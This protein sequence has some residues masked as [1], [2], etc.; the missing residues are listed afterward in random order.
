MGAS[1][2]TELGQGHSLIRTDHRIRILLSVPLVNLD[3]KDRSWQTVTS[4]ASSQI[5]L[6]VGRK[7][8]RCGTNHV[9]LVVQEVDHTC[10]LAHH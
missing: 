1:T 10:F 9:L 5:E 2:Q 7:L 4:P 3:H 6:V 8:I